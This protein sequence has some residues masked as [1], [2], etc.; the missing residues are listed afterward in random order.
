MW[1]KRKTASDHC[2]F[3]AIDVKLFFSVPERILK[4]KF[5][6]FFSHHINEK[7]LFSGVEKSSSVYY[8]SYNP[9]ANLKLRPD[10]A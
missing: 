4:K 7:S 9:T 1:Y 3:K 5:H 10:S 8:Q 2:F 6:N